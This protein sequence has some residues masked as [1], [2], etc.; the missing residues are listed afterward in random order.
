M[1]DQAQVT[2]Q[3]RDQ[4]RGMARGGEDDIAGLIRVAVDE[5]IAASGLDPRTY[6]LV[7]IAALIATRAEAP[8]FLVH[9]TRGV[10]AGVTPDELLGVL[11]ALAPSVGIPKVVDA[12]P[13]IAAALDIDLELAERAATGAGGGAAGDTAD[14][15]DGGAGTPAG[16]GPGS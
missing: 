5:N 6:S 10:V 9:V 16:G 1:T 15:G 14:A 3:H 11:T 7:N 2:D 4:F 13:R 8:S 12:A